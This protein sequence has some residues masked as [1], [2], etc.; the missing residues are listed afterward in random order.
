MCRHAA[1]VG[2]PITLGRFLGDPPH[3]LIEQAYKPR[4]MLTAELNADGFGLGWLL[5]DGSPA[6]YT[7][8]MPVWSDVNLA[9][10]GRALASPVWLGNVR[11]ATRG[12]AVNQAN[13]HPFLVGRQLFSHNGFIDAFADG[14]RARLRAHLEARHE[15]AIR[16]TTDSEYLFAALRQEGDRAASPEEALRRLLGRVGDWLDGGHGLFNLLLVEGDCAYATRHAIG[17]ESPSLY[18]GSDP[19]FQDGWLVASEPFSDDSSWQ[20]VPDHHLVVLAPGARP[21][22]EPL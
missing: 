20:P 7:N 10:L 17:H 19:M 12:M 14:P 15:A 22:I 21:R 9:H 16:G 4:Q 2:P 8:P 3:G 13:T 18:V 6:V 1:Y 5:P 11:S